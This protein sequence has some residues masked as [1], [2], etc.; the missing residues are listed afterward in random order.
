MII[1][2]LIAAALATGLATAAAN[3]MTVIN[4]DKSGHEF[5]FTPKN[6][7]LHRYSL[8]GHHHRSIDCRSGGTV[9]MGKL[10]QSC[11]AKTARIFIKAGKF[12][13]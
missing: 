8:A 6:G 11:D 1:R 4:S 9:T 2:T 13:M 3:A 12:E 7:K 5:S 10:A